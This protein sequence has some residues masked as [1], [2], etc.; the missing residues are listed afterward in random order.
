MT[1]LDTP[2]KLKQQISDMEM[3]NPP[4]FAPAQVAPKSDEIARLEKEMQECAENDQ[5]TRAME[6]K[7][8]V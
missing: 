7:K 8:Q 4:A 2:P 3:T 6:I 1:H 5:F